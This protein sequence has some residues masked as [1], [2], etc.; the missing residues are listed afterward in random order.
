MRQIPGPAS[1]IAI[2]TEP[3]EKRPASIDQARPVGRLGP[4]RSRVFHFAFCGVLPCVWLESRGSGAEPIRSR[5]CLDG[6]WRERSRSRGNI[7]SRCGL[8]PSLRIRGTE[9]LRSRFALPSL[10]RLPDVSLGPP[11]SSMVVGRG[12]QGGAR[13]RGG[14]CP[15][16]ELEAAGHRPVAEE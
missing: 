6:E 2:R 5:D 16:A 9:P 1:R 3:T 14:A 7:P 10:P 15:R 4:A 11:P 13:A 8:A 12:C